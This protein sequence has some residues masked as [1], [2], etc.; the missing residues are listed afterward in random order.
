L[1]LPQ[2]DF[3]E[4]G[5]LPGG[6]SPPPVTAVLVTAGDRRPQ[7]IMAGQALHRIMLH[8]ASRWVFASLQ[9]QPLEI[10]E[11]RAELKARLNL[12]GAPHMILQFGRSNIAQATPRRLASD[13]IA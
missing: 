10:P 8:A 5:V 6:G 3:G 7:W 11:L 13:I 12:P 2:R 1:R 4:S 9:S